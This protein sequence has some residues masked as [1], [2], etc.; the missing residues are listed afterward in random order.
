MAEIDIIK[1]KFLRGMFDQNTYVLTNE[2]EAV[3]IDAGADLEDVKNVIKD[4]KVLAVFITHAHFDH[5]WCI[6]DYVK[7]FDCDVYFQN[8]A[9]KKLMDPKLNASVLMQSKTF[10]IGQKNIKYYAENLNIGSFSF[11]VYSTPGH[12]FDCVCIL[13]GKNLF[14]GDTI[15]VDGVGRTD[16]VDSN[17][18]EM[19]DSLKTILSIDFDVAYSGHY[20][21]STKAEVERNIKSYL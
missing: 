4:K 12:A 20:E 16:L 8:G 13:W 15:F 18:F 2:K 5:L 10:N 7:E 1:G 6:E 14:V 21:S 3:I 19:I 17:P 11:K 9:D